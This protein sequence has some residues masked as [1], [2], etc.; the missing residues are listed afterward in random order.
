MT[1]TLA[2]ALRASAF[3][4]LALAVSRVDLQAQDRDRDS[5]NGDRTAD[6]R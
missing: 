2:K 4:V 3:A 1:N 5:R 6:F